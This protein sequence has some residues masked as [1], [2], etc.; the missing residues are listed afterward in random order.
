MKYTI[1]INQLAL[2]NTKLDLKDATILDYLI[3]F[4][5]A[6]DK[7]IKQLSFSEGGKD[8]RYTWINFN[9][10]IKEMPLLRLKSKASISDRITNIQKAGFI[11]TFKAPDRSLYIRLT[12][13]IKELE[14][15]RGVRQTEQECSPNRIGL[16]GNPNSTIKELINPLS[17]ERERVDEIPTLIQKPL[18]PIQQ[19]GEYFLEYCIQTKGF[20]PIISWQ[21]EGSM[22]KRFLLEYSVDEL[23]QELQWF[24]DSNEFEKFG[25]TIKVAL[26][27][28]VFNKWLAQRNL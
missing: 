13:K 18:T 8:Y 15:S 26:S 1:R 20:K 11:K 7:N 14:F 25:C 23:K 22:I 27:N 3:G 5:S 4:C 24:L 10:L 17:I 21:I 2:A 28:Y 9:Y 6:D 12:E 16:F 19:V